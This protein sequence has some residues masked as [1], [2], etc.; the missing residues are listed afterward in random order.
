M[1]SPKKKVKAKSAGKF[2][3]LKSKRNPK[4]GAHQSYLSQDVA[5]PKLG[6][7]SPK[8]GWIE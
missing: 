6:V 4:G 5:S 8:L 3:D 1:A 2:K 7:T